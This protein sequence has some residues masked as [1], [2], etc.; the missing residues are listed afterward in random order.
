MFKITFFFILAMVAFVVGGV[1][2]K[3]ELYSPDKGCQFALAQVPIYKQFLKP[4]LAFI[5]NQ[6]LA[7][8]SD[9]NDTSF[10]WRYDI[11]KDQWT[12][13]T[14][15]KYSHYESPGI[16]LSNKL[17][18]IDDESPEVYDFSN[19]LWSGWPKPTIKTGRSPCLITWKDTIIAIGGENN[20]K[21]VQ[22]FNTTSEVW[23]VLDG[24]APLDF[25]RHACILL[26]NN[27][28]LVVGT[29]SLSNN[30]SALYNIEDNL[31]ERVSDTQLIRGGSTLFNLNGRHFVIG[32]GK[33]SSTSYTNLVEEYN[34]VTKTWDISASP[35]PLSSRCFSSGLSLP[36]SLFSNTQRQ[37]I[38]ID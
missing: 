37:C 20:T 32:G 23:T 26:P 21:R 24:K 7:C 18:I 9:T 3:V 10:C 36:A 25:Y 5:N 33:E 38:G 13:I 6:I 34:L 8:P 22:S 31:W 4:S 12:N 28:V 17:Y 11:A 15:P 19:D 30:P 29:W 27:K 35:K 1:T 14:S 2:N 16:A